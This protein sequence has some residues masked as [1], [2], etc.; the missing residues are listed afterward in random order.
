MT[1]NS[2]FKIEEVAKGIYATL[3]VDMEHA[4]GNA[5]IVDLGNETLVFD[6]FASP[7]AGAVLK[8][9]ATELTGKIPRWVVN[10]HHH[11]DHVLGNQCFA[12]EATFIATDQTRQDII[13]LDERVPS[14]RQRTVEALEALRSNEEDDVE[15][16][17]E[18]IAKLEERLEF[19]D[20]L[21]IIVPTIL[22]ENKL[23]LQGAQQSVHILNFGGG[24]TA[25]D[26]FIHLP[27]TG[28]VLLADLLFQGEA[29]P[30]IGDGD[31]V[32]WVRILEQVLQIPADIFVPGHG[33][34]ADRKDVERQF[35][36]M[37]D[38]TALIE[39]KRRD[40]D[41]EVRIPDPYRSWEGEE[42]FEQSVTALTT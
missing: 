36:Y 17:A 8:Q 33:N 11:G 18:Q 25:S 12:D 10:S 5:A 39:Q 21:H 9:V 16:R 13:A 32:E 20:T 41:F 24:H 35:K 26:S 15:D 40:P 38:F 28:V 31:P 4:L 23:A 14:I 3:A 1:N 37:Q 34:I 27:D 2:Y 6:T 29:H 7:Q 19:L 22:F 42:W 30:W